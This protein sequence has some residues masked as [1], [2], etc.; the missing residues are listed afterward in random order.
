MPRPMR[1]EG[2]VFTPPSEERRVHPQAITEMVESDHAKQ[3]FSEEPERP[4]GEDAAEQ[5]NP[6]G[7]NIG[8]HI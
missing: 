8:E 6:H 7:K 1:R 5:D 2:S 3:P 4:C